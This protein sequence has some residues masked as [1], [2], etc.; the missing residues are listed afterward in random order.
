M[1]TLKHLFAN[2]RTWAK[3]IRRRDPE[4]FRKLSKQQAPAY[5]WIGCSDSRVPANQIVGL[6]PGEMFVHRN[7]ANVVA[8]SDL[9]CMSVLQFALDI[10]K[11]RHVIV[12][13]HYGC[14]GVRAAES[15]ARLG[16]PSKWLAHVGHVHKKHERPLA[17]VAG[18]RARIDRL[19]E[20]NVIEQV[21]NVCRSSICH[22]A[23]Q[24]GQPLCVHGWI[25]GVGNGLLRDLKVTISGPSELKQA[26]QNAILTL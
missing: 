7:L 12:C 26:Y 15:G 8:E 19:C 17:S 24:R 4:F 10:L 5:L 25:Y 20:L 23:W 18:E 13:G 1:K 22:A 2:N 9:N 21:R 6:L 3:D 14:A 11:I 16:L